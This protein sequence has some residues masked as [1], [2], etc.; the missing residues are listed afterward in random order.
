MSKTISF[1][2]LR[3]IKDQL[4]DGAI[5][6]IAERLNLNDETVRNYFGGTDFKEGGAVGIH[7][8]Q[9]PDGGYV[10][11]DDTTILDIA[12]EIIEK[13]KAAAGHKSCCHCS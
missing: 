6:Q 8:E 11:L 1:N 5:H 7:V 13:D 10:T 12:L 9:G 2:Q 4:P 3:S